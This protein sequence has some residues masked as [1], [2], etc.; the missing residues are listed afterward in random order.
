ML[1]RK[2]FQKL[3]ALERELIQRSPEPLAPW[4]HQVNGQLSQMSLDSVQDLTNKVLRE[5][6]NF[7]HSLTDLKSPAQ[8]GGVRELKAAVRAL[9]SPSHPSFSASMAEVNAHISKCAI[10]EENRR[11]TKVQR[12][13][14]QCTRVEKTLAKALQPSEPPTLAMKH[15]S[16][17]GKRPTDLNEI[18]N[19]FS[20]TLLHLGGDPS[21]LP[22][23][24][25][26]R[27]LFQHTP[28][29]PPEVTSQPLRPIEW[30]QFTKYISRAK[31]TK[32]GGCD[33]TSAYIFH[34]APEA[35]QKFFLHVCNLHLNSPIP[36]R[37]LKANV[38]LLFKKKDPEL[39]TNYRP[40]ALHDTIYKVLFTHAATFLSTFDVDNHLIHSSRFGGLKNRRTSDHIYQVI[41]NFQHIPQS[42]SLYIDF[43]KAFNSVPQPTLWRVLRHIGAP[44][45]S[46][47]CSK[48]STATPK[49]P[50]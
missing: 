22:P 42:Y 6:A 3:K 48:T 28:S 45:P 39:P 49:N 13:L 38:V 4:C 30:L 19:I 7:F 14:V 20:N 1:Q 32:A 9:P 46:S 23:D 17:P 27:D 33:S 40:I 21:F 10:Q 37:W 44:P 25:L 11:N 18:S 26:G 12:C 31:P 29:C 43:N 5:T 24:N 15:S 2:K 41:S 35:M 50:R 8:P 16:T 36:P 47:S 34:C